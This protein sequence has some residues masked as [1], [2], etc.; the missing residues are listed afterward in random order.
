MNRHACNLRK[1][2]PQFLITEK[3]KEFSA[4]TGDFVH[5]A[6]FLESKVHYFATL[7]RLQ[8]GLASALVPRQRVKLFIE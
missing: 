4:G 2:Q 1:G 5:A 6:A 7:D 8:A 3:G